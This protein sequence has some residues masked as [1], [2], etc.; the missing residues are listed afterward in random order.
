MRTLDP[1]TLFK[2]LGDETRLMLVLLVHRH[3]E[4]CVCQFTEVLEASQPKVSRHLA[5]LRACG[6]LSD[7]RDSQWVYYALAPDLP[8]WARVALSA[9]AEARSD[10][11][12]QAEERLSRSCV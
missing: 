11:L 9:A 10:S 4:L 12:I 1:V 3:G 5:Q 2:C 7:R 8:E 6:I